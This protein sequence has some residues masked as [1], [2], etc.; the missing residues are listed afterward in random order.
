[1]ADATSKDEDDEEVTYNDLN[2][3]QIAYQELLSNSSTL[4]I[5]YKELKKKFDSLKKENDVLKKENEK[6][7]GKQTKD[8]YKVNTSKVNEQLQKEV[9]DLRQSLAKFVI[10]SENLKKLLKYNRHPHNKFGLGFD[11]KK[12]I[13]KNKSNVHY[14][15]C[16]KFGHMFYD[17]KECP[18]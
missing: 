9:I 10:G 12:E 5:G 3:L 17:Y 18:K 4:S 7:K 14:L 6:L 1:M 2:C 11:K 15:N 16:R 13:K 8:I